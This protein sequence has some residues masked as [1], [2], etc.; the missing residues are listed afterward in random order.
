[1]ELSFFNINAGFPEAIVRGL[2]SGF[3]TTDDYRRLGAAESLEDIR[4]ALDDTDYGQFLQDEPSPLLVQT[5]VFN[6]KKRLADEFRFIRAQSAEPLVKFLDF[7]TYGKMIDNVMSLIQGTINK[8]PAAELLARVDPLGWFEEMKTIPNMD[9]SGGYD[10]IYKTILIETPVGPYFE[11]FLKSVGSEE[12]KS[13]SDVSNIFSE[14]DLEL[15]KQVLKKAWLE[16]FYSFVGDVGG[17]TEEVMGHILK[18]EADARVLL[19]TLN[20]LNTPLGTAQQLHD[21]NAL[22]P[23]FGYLYPEGTDKIRKAW[24]ET[25]VSAALEPYGRYKTLFEQVKMFYD[26][27][28]K[29]DR[30]TGRVK[31]LEDLLYVES[32]KMY[33]LTF[34]QQYHYGVFYAWAKLREQ[35]IRN[36]EWICNMV[37]MANK[38]HMDDI[39]PIFAPRN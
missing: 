34:E 28:K 5:I 36:I 23:H 2:R 37:V 22:Y 32:A 11:E 1:M 25:T 24:N 17:T 15:M 38:E 26:N 35:E 4:T 7:I 10:D 8:K 16:D 6:A 39:V 20:A 14:M 9:I 19:V 21:R 13:M 33:E 27:E 3:L 12:G 30:F 18:T 31:S 29:H